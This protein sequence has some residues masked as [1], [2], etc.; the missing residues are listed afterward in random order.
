MIP[1]L[2]LNLNLNLSLSQNQLLPLPLLLMTTMKITKTMKKTTQTIQITLII[3]MTRDS[4]HLMES[5]SIGEMTGNLMDL[6][7]TRKAVDHAGVSQP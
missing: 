6:S 1:S 2:N 5:T 7:K 4:L 3:I